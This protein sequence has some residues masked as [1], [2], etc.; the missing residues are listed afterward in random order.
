MA[1]ARIETSFCRNPKVAKLSLLAE[2]LYVRGLEHAREQ[3]TDGYLSRASLASIA[4]RFRRPKPCV[5][6]LVKEGFWEPVEDGWRVHDYLDFNPS[7]AQIRA[8]MKADAERKR[9]SRQAGDKADVRAD[10]PPDVPPDV[11]T[12]SARSSPK[13]VVRSPENQHQHLPD[14]GAAAPPAAEA[15]STNGPGPAQP[16]W[17]SPAA[18]VDLYNSAVPPGH[19]RVEKLSAGRRRKADEY[20]RQFPEESYWRSAFSEI[21]RSSLLQGLRPSPG[22]EGFKGTFD[23]LLTKGKDGTE[24]IV[25]VAEGRYRDRETEDEEGES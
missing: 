22:H 12:E 21:G 25:K 3:L 7:A 10:V 18:L 14:F 1:W 13:S 8:A 16:R 6:Q 9:R 17:P 19:Q 5:E 23:W 11:R 4:V 2:L 20:L 24:N 15:F